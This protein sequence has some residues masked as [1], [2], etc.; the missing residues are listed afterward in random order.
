M[1]A[2]D[3]ET[4]LS[5]SS[6]N[7]NPHVERLEA[8]LKQQLDQTSTYT[9]SKDCDQVI[10]ELRAL[11]QLDKN[12][13]Q[14]RSS[15]ATKGGISLFAAAVF[16]FLAIPTLG[17]TAIIGIP[18]LIY[19][20]TQFSKRSGLSN[21]DVQDR[22]YLAPINILEKLKADI[23]PGQPVNVK[24]DFNDYSNSQ[25]EKS[26]EGGGVF[27]AVKRNKY[28]I[29][30]FELSGCLMEG[31]KFR[32]R[33]SQVIKRKSKTK[34]R[35]T[36]ISESLREKYSIM[37]LP[38]ADRYMDLAALPH[39]I[40]LQKQAHDFFDGMI[41]PEPSVQVRDGR[42]IVQSLTSTVTRTYMHGTPP[43]QPFQDTLGTFSLNLF[44]LT[45]AG[46]QS[47]K[48]GSQS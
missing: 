6:I 29:L 15:L 35:G 25:Y 47:I 30:W 13:E 21:Y 38:A 42:A 26:S 1:N 22:F 8:A 2:L 9:A 33:I 17:A 28:E 7:G 12:T 19:G 34:K 3:I 48:T 46:L 37:L 24:I 16:L 43:R 11:G 5:P 20:I 4:N 14:L 41:A 31:T 23:P 45:F 10:T 44:R 39:A 27:S 36:K 40:R 32:L 18:A